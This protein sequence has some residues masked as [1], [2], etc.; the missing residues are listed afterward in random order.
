MSRLDTKWMTM[1][2]KDDLT[3]EERAEFDRAMRGV[4]PLNSTNKRPTAAKPTTQPRVVKPRAP[5]IDSSP[6]YYNA[7]ASSAEEKL[8]YART[9]VHQN[10]LRRLKRGQLS[11]GAEL[12]L[13]GLTADE[14]IAESSKFLSQCRQQDIRCVCIIHGKGLQ[15]TNSQAVL[16]SHLNGYLRVHT[17]VL[18]FSSAPPAQGGTG[19]LLVLLKARD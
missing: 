6:V 13:H 1:S 14:A 10:T 8:W 12:D 17:D 5:I 3:P 2:D 7:K 16:K 9:G 18:A 15:S 19:A 11:I 4:K